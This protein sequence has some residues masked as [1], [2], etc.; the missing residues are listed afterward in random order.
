MDG[1]IRKIIIQLSIVLIRSYQT[2]VN[3]TFITIKTT[4]CIVQKAKESKQVTIALKARFCFIQNR[5]FVMQ[6]ICLCLYSKYSTWISPI[7]IKIIFLLKHI[8]SIVNK[9]LIDFPISHAVDK[10]YSILNFA[11]DCISY[12]YKSK[13][14]VVYLIKCFVKNISYKRYTIR[15][16]LAI[17]SR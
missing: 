10:I 4:R 14:S 11:S 3:I 16:S 7:T 13:T 15:F 6:S 12:P 8:A 17:L 5:A 1:R 2:L 9:I